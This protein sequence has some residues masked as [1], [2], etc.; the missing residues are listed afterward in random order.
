MKEPCP[1]HPPPSAQTISFSFLHWVLIALHLQVIRQ[2]GECEIKVNI[3][4]STVDLVTKTDERVEKI[5]I[6]ALKEEFG[7]GTHW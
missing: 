3:K 7:E 4:S 6:G 1:P 2:A 5:I